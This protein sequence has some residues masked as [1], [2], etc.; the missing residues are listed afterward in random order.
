MPTRSA[1]QRLRW[2][3]Q[4]VFRGEGRGTPAF[5]RGQERLELRHPERLAEEAIGAGGERIVGGGELIPKGGEHYARPVKD[6]DLR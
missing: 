3:G 2:G 6:A 4:G 5:D 1:D